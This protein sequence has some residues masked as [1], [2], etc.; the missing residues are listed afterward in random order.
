AVDRGDE[1]VASNRVAQAFGKRQVWTSV[2]EQG[3]AGDD[4]PRAG[5]EK[6]LR[7]RDAAHA[8]AHAARERCRD[9]AHEREVIARPG[10]RAEIDDLDFWKRGESTHPREYVLVADCE[11]FALNQLDDGAALKVDRGNQHATASAT[12]TRKH[13]KPLHIRTGM[14]W[15]RRYSF[16]A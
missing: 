11:P 9:R 10:R 6:V 1:P 5:R 12:K 16:R 4:L 3:R 13:E 14:R 7:A 15:S 2:L 8:A